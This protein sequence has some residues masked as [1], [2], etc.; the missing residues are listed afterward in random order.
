[1]AEPY[2]YILSEYIKIGKESAKSVNSCGPE[3][4]LEDARALGFERFGNTYTAAEYNVATVEAETYV[5]ANYNN[6]FSRIPD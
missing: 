5:L 2:D 4:D 6:L 3:K 1:M